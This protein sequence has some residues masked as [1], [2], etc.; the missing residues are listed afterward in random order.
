MI[1]QEQPRVEEQTERELM[2]APDYCISHSAS[3][4]VVRK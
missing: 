2:I 4:R 3:L 1:L